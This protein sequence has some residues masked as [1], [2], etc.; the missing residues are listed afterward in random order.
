MRD[1]M[2]AVNLS[3]GVPGRE[4]GSGGKLR[5]KVFLK[6]QGYGLTITDRA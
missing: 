2:P 6:G 5:A 4:R 3:R 1:Q